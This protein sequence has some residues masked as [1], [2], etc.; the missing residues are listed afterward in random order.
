MKKKF[1]KNFEISL[2]HVCEVKKPN[3]ESVQLVKL[4]NSSLNAEWEGE[5]S[6]KSSNWNGV[7]AEEKKR[8]GFK[9][10]NDEGFYMSFEDWIQKFKYFCICE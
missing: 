5:W 6:A 4:L 2:L 3:G 1:Y 10:K 9:K 7:S 8:I